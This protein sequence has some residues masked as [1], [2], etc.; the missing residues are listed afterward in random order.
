MGLRRPTTSLPS[1]PSCP[2]DKP[3]PGVDPYPGGSTCPAPATAAPQQ[4]KGKFGLPAG[5]PVGI[6]TGGIGSMIPGGKTGATVSMLV[7]QKW[8]QD[9]KV[10]VDAIEEARRGGTSGGAQ[11]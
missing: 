6:P 7:P 4:K 5:L 10:V 9:L 8:Q 11:K 3:S 1:V 2:G